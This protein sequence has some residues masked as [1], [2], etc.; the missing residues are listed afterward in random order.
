M[1][2]RPNPELLADIAEI[3]VRAERLFLKCQFDA[4]GDAETE[5]AKTGLRHARGL[6]A[7]VTDLPGVT[8]RQAAGATQ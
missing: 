8:P 5:W 2:M 1:P 4:D 7:V 6:K 3:A